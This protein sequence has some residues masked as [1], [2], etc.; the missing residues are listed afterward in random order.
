MRNAAY[1]NHI[2]CFHFLL[3]QF[4][5]HTHHDEFELF[6]DLNNIT[7]AT[8]IAYIA[9]STTTFYNNNPG[10]RIYV[11]DGFYPSTTWRVVDY[12]TYF[13]NLTEAN[14]T[15]EPKWQLEYTAKVNICI[16]TI[17]IYLQ[18]ISI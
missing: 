11:V 2:H 1:L 4:F 16:K 6:Y 15:N 13:L 17:K 7:R 9:P 5:G 8:N 10:Y 18:F 14:I 3:G 12:E